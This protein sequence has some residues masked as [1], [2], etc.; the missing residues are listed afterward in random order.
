M[1]CVVPPVT[2]VREGWKLAPR[3]TRVE[4]DGAEGGDGDAGDCGGDGPEVAPPLGA[5]A[6]PNAMRLTGPMLARL[7]LQAKEFLP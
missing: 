5:N 3:A 4:G 2:L 1:G 7:W 6:L